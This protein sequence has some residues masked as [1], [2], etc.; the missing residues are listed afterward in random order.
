MQSE[1][2][3]D[4]MKWLRRKRQVDIAHVA[5]RQTELKEL[6]FRISMRLQG[7]VTSDTPKKYRPLSMDL[8]ILNEHSAKQSTRI[9][10]RASFYGRDS[11]SKAYKVGNRLNGQRVRRRRKRIK[12]KQLSL[13]KTFA[14]SSVF[15]EFPDDGTATGHA[16][17]SF[18]YKPKRFS[19]ISDRKIRDDGRP[20]PY[21]RLNPVSYV[22]PKHVWEP[23]GP[24]TY[25]PDPVLRKDKHGNVVR[26]PY[27]PPAKD[28]QKIRRLKKHRQRVQKTK[29]KY[30][31]YKLPGISTACF[32]GERLLH[33]ARERRG[34]L[35][36][37]YDEL[38]DA[39]IKIT[40]FFRNGRGI[41]KIWEW[42]D[43]MRSI[44]LLNNSATVITKWCRRYLAKRLISEWHQSALTIQCLFRQFK[45][46]KE[47]EKR[48]KIKRAKAEFR[49]RMLRKR[50]ARILQRKVRRHLKVVHYRKMIGKMAMNIQRRARGWLARKKTSGMKKML[51]NAT[52]MAKKIQRGARRFLKRRFNLKKKRE[53]S[54]VQIQAAFR[55]QRDREIAK[56]TKRQR[57]IDS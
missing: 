38:N 34:I 45:S 25:T 11:R 33:K 37:T 9:N 26:V 1:T 32:I 7:R 36:K 48:K 16:S 20:R 42:K 51:K 18:G 47:V 30:M 6:T 49:Q 5:E 39:T 56:E 41:A 19:N 46:R 50:A 13:E 27:E 21:K 2:F 23:V 29:P 44:V 17:K 22:R 4:T 3:F 28:T 52:R 57:D 12:L 35:Q 53:K 31:K 54:A 55:G 40:K 24:S 8:N 15:D 14:G 43:Q 10:K